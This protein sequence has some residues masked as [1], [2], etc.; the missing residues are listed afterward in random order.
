LYLGL[1][2]AY[3]KNLIGPMIAHGLFDM[4]GMVYFRGFMLRLQN[5]R[6]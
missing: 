5:K 6:T 1:F 4:A 2:F 3:S